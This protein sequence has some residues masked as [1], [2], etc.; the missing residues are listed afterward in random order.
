MCTSTCVVRMCMCTSCRCCMYV[1]I[2]ARVC[3][4]IYRTHVH[5]HVCYA[6]Y[7]HHVSWCIHMPSVCLMMFCLHMLCRRVLCDVL[8]AC[9]CLD[10]PLDMRARLH[11]SMN[12]VKDC[13]AIRCISEGF[14]R[15]AVLLNGF[16]ANCCAW[17]LSR[18]S[19][20]PTT[21]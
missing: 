5:A 21:Q 10:V 12:I 7:A 1:Y 6:I 14:Y 15:D 18:R 9:A 19:T 3:G 11:A 8:V 17:L 2:C 20:C 16:I 4:R 13:V